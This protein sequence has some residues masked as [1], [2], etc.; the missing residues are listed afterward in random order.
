MLYEAAS[1]GGGPGL[2]VQG[3]ASASGRR[4]RFFDS[5]GD[6][7]QGTGASFDPRLDA[8]AAH[9]VNEI[10]QKQNEVS[11]PVQNRVD[12]RIF[13]NPQN[14]RFLPLV[15]AVHIYT[16]YLHGPWGPHGGFLEPE[17]ANNKAWSAF[18]SELRKLAPMTAKD[19]VDG[20]TEYVKYGTQWSCNCGVVHTAA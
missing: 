14:V 12:A 4:T 7:T 2:I 17:A 8:G 11:T 15:T 13:L 5:A 3:A 6:F 20:G 9:W 18:I 10:T 1:M 16:L 19:P